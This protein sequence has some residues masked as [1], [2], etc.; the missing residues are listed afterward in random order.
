MWMITGENLLIIKQAEKG[1][2]AGMKRYSILKMRWSSTMISL[3]ASTSN[4]SSIHV[5]LTLSIHFWLRLPTTVQK[6]RIIRGVL[7]TGVTS[8][9]DT[10]DT[11]FHVTCFHG[12]D[13]D[14]T[15][16]HSGIA[17]H[18]TGFPGLPPYWPPRYQNFM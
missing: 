16:L 12:T 5:W 7:A 11:C 14:G 10:V 8:Y 15:G 3:Q 9:G 6:L 18:S 4:L 2:S 1:I 13:I 17:F